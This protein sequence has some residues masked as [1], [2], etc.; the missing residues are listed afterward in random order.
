MTHSVRDI[1]KKKKKK[2]T[3]RV[4]GFDNSYPRIER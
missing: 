3:R 2:K 4:P 1:E